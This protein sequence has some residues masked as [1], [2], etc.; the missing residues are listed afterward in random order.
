MQKLFSR[1]NLIYLLVFLAAILLTVA[2]AALLSN[3]TQRKAEAVLTSY[4]I[5]PIDEDELDPAVWG[6]NFPYHYERF[7]LTERSDTET[8]YGGS[9]PYSK[10]ERYPAMVRL[11]AGY[12]FSKDHNEERGHYWAQIDQ[13]NTLRVKI[14]DQPGACINCHSANAPRLI[15][16][17]GWEEFNKTPYNDLVE[18][19]HYGSSCADCHDPDTMALR[20]T[21]PAF[22]NAMELRGIDL[23]QASRQEMRT[24]VCA[25]CHVEYYFEG[26]NKVLTFPWELGLN[27]DDISEYYQSYGF[28]D[29]T[30]AE[31]GAPMIKIQH[32]EFEMWSS[33]LHAANGVS[34]ADCHM[35]YERVGAVKVSDHW[36]RSPLTN[37]AASCQTCHNVSVEELE[38]RVLNA[39]DTTA[40]LL[41]ATEEAIIDAIDTIV[42]AREAG[43][44][45]ED[46]AEALNFHREASLRWDFVS[47]ENSTGF[48]SPQEAA[49]I[50]AHAI[51]LA[52][53]AELAALAVTP[54]TQ[55]EN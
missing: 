21:R 1:Q 12:S 10:L 16:E 51:D 22:I 5:E 35:P 11:W 49:R 2:V 15:E 43:A 7:L 45:D 37:L 25:Q 8:P 27:I 20:I 28:Q 13:E 52:R 4:V 18:E 36:L 6:Q 9:V 32:P 3:I 38:R 54:V 31:T 42:A 24:Y 39:Q 14:V 50:L 29:W 19:L 40:E 44:T 33:S 30:H 48:H 23:S 17:L 55:A 53:Q 46:L 47:S 26:D 34:C 41:R